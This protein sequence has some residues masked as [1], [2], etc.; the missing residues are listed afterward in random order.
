MLCSARGSPRRPL[1]HRDVELLLAAEVVVDHP[2][3]RAGVIG[4][5]VDARAGDSRVGE[6][7][8]GDLEDLAAR[9]LGVALAL[10]GGNVRVR[11]ECQRASL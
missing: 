11:S 8:R 10:G 3:G 1:E 6:L 2:L 5:L 9:L 7:P 4:D